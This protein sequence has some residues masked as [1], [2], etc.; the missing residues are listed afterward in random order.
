[1]IHTKKLAIVLAMIFMI[2]IPSVSQADRVDCPIL[3]L[4]VD[5]GYYL[6]TQPYNTAPEVGTSVHDR[7]IQILCT[8]GNA[9]WPYAKHPDTGEIHYIHLECLLIDLNDLEIGLFGTPILRKGDRGE[10]IKNLQRCLNYLGYNTGKIDSIFGSGTEK[11]LRSFQRKYELDTDGK[12][13]PKT[14]YAL[15]VATHLNELC[16][17]VR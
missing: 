8:S 1:M 9:W 15:L 10:A 12:V 3:T 6:Q 16:D 2:S 5:R 7:S 4:K 11:A 17:R 14:K 13:G